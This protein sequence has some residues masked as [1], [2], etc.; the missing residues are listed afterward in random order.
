MLAL[1]SLNRRHKAGLFLVLVAAGLSL[2]FE[3]SAKQTAGI[4]LLGLAAMWF[5]GSVR[6][7]TLGLILA[8]TGCC[9][10]LY[11]VI[12]PVWKEHQLYRTRVQAYDQ[13]LSDIRHLGRPIRITNLDLR[14]R[15]LRL[16]RA[17][18]RYG[19]PNATQLFR[20]ERKGSRAMRVVLG[21]IA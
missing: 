19:I 5:F 2:F 12:A 8:S 16:Q 18:S 6:P 3:A 7:G 11:F 4:I 21:L 15:E 13:V 17:N 14:S 10:G 1:P 9:V 20:P